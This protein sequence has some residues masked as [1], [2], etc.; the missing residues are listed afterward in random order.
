MNLED[1]PVKLPLT[2]IK[3]IHAAWIV[4]FYNH[5]TTEKGRDVI[6]RGWRAAG[7]TDA[8]I[9]GSK[10]L[11]SID[12]FEHIDPMLDLNL[13]NPN[14]EILAAC[15]LSAEL[16]ELHIDRKDTITSDSSDSE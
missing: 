7:I 16:L 5:M 11:P 4:D 1:I 9:K 15:E 12:P 3:P 6:E 8:L 13:R 2:T 14:E 10:D